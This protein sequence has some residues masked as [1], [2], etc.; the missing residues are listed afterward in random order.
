ML[1]RNKKR[2]IPHSKSLK[3]QNERK[4]QL[5]SRKTNLQ[6]KIPY[7]RN[8]LRHPQKITQI[9]RNTKKN[10]QK[11]TNR[12]NTTNNSPQHKNH[13]KTPKTTIKTKKTC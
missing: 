4:L 11:S 12:T 8:L 2:N 1:Q 5:R 7:R 10:H 9:P 6:K 3:N 13:T